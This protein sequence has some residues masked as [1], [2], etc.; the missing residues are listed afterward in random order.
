MAFEEIEQFIL[1]GYNSASRKIQVKQK[2]N[3][4][5]MQSF[6]IEKNCTPEQDALKS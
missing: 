1:V 6:M 2:L 5:E 4:L 3:A